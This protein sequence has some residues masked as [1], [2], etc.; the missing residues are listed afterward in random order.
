MQDTQQTFR[1]WNNSDREEG[2]TVKEALAADPR[3]RSQTGFG[4]KPL[5]MFMLK[6]CG[7]VSLFPLRFALNNSCQQLRKAVVCSKSFFFASV[8]L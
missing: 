4:R 3:F 2:K 5:Q 7:N 1:S 8:L 6:Q